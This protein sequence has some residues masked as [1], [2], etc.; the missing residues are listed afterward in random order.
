MKTYMKCGVCHQTSSKIVA[1]VKDIG[2][3]EECINKI[4][5]SVIKIK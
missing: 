5:Q 4:K 2:I 3:C 1:S